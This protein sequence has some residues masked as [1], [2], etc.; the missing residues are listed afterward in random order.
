MYTEYINYYFIL[1]LI[2]LYNIYIIKEARY[3]NNFNLIFHMHTHAY[4]YIYICN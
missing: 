1:Q 3:K 4:I 2:L